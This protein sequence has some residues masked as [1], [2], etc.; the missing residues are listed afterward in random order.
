MRFNC[1]RHKDDFVSV[2]HNSIYNKLVIS[3]EEAG[4]KSTIVLSDKDAVELAE[5]ILS[6]F[7]EDN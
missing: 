2:S 4:D 3:V 1:D 6:H 5:E 7:K